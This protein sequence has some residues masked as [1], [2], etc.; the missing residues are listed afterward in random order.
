MFKCGV[1]GCSYTAELKKKPSGKQYI[2]YHCTGK[3]KIKTCKKESYISESKID[4]FLAE[5]LKGLSDIP[6]YV[7]DVIKN[8]L[9]IVHDL[10]NEYSIHSQKNIEKRIKEIDRM[11]QNGYKRMLKNNN[12][13]ENEL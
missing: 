13:Y 4:A 7:I 5:I 9:K 2:Y 12:E 8:E 11:I 6:Q 3:G 1:C 10:K